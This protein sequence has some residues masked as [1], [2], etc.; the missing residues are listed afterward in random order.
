ME[1]WLRNCHLTDQPPP[2]YQKVLIT[3]FDKILITV[4][5]RPKNNGSVTLPLMDL[6]NYRITYFR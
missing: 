3:Y 5:S 6:T 1:T 2:N 4:S